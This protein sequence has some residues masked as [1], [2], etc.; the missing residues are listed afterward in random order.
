MD[1]YDPRIDPQI[2]AAIGLRVVR[3]FDFSSTK[4]T[5]MTREEFGVEALRQAVNASTDGEASAET[6]ARAEAFYAFLRGPAPEQQGETAS[7][8]AA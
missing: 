5:A 4:G 3:A 6:V 1:V 2:H 8:K 7:E